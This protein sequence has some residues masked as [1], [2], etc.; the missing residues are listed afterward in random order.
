MGKKGKGEAAKEVAKPEVKEEPVV[1][2]VATN[3]LVDLLGP[4]I[5]KNNGESEAM[6]KYKESESTEKALRGRSVIG[7]FFA[8]LQ[9]PASKAFS[10]ILAKAYRESLYAKGLE[11]VFIS[12]DEK[13][14]DGMTQYAQQ[15]EAMSCVKVSAES[16]SETSDFWY[17]LPKDTTFQARTEL[18]DKFHGEG[19]D[20]NTAL[21]SEGEPRSWFTTPADGKYYSSGNAD[22]HLQAFG[23]SAKFILLSLFSPPGG[24]ASIVISEEQLKRGAGN[25]IAVEG[26]KGFQI[27]IQVGGQKDAWTAKVDAIGPE[28]APMTGTTSGKGH[29]G[30]DGLIR[31]WVGV[32]SPGKVINVR[33][34]DGHQS[35]AGD[36]LGVPNYENAIIDAHAAHEDQP[37]WTPSDF[38]LRAEEPKD[39]DAAVIWTFETRGKEPTVLDLRSPD[40]DL[41]GIYVHCPYA[42]NRD[43]YRKK[44]DVDSFN[45]NGTYL[46]YH[47]TNRAWLADAKGSGLEMVLAMSDPAADHQSMIPILTSEYKYKSGSADAYSIEFQQED[48]GEGEEC[49][50]LVLVDAKGNV[51]THDGVF[52]V[53]TD[54]TGTEFPWAAPKDLTEEDILLRSGLVTPPV[55]EAGIKPILIR[56][57]QYMGY[58][59]TDQEEEDDSVPFSGGNLKPYAVLSKAQIL[60]DVRKMGFANDFHAISKDVEK[61]Q[62]DNLLLLYDPE[63][64]HGERLCWCSTLAAYEKW[65]GIIS[66][67][68]GKHDVQ[69]IAS[70]LRRIKAVDPGQEDL[71]KMEKVLLGKK[72]ETIFQSVAAKLRTA[73]TLGGFD[74]KNSECVTSVVPSSNL[75][76]KARSYAN[77]VEQLWKAKAGSVV[78][79]LFANC[80]Q[81]ADNKPLDRPLLTRL[82][83][84]F[85][86][87][88]GDLFTDERIKSSPLG[89]VA[90][91]LYTMQDVDLDRM[92]LF[93]DVPEIPEGE[94][95][96]EARDRN[97]LPYRQKH[98]GEGRN[99]CMFGEACWALRSCWEAFAGGWENAEA[100]QKLRKWVKWATLVGSLRQKLSLGK[101]VTRGLTQLPDAVMEDLMKRKPDDLIFWGTLSSTTLDPSIS[102]NYANQ[103]RPVN[104]NIVITI[105][106]LDEGIPL[107]QISQYPMEQEVLL[108]CFSMLRVREV[109]P[110]TSPDQPVRMSCEYAGCLIPDSLQGLAEKD[111]IRSMATLWEAVKEAEDGD[112]DVVVRDLP[113]DCKDWVSD[114]AEETHQEVGRFTVNNSRSLLRVMIT[115][116]RAHF[117]KTHKFSDSGEN[118][119]YC[120]PQKDPNYTQQRKELEMGIQAVKE[121]SEQSCQTAW[122]RPVNK[123]TQYSPKDFLPNGDAELGYDKV[124]ELTEFLEKVSVRVEESLQTNETVDIFQ[125]EFAHLGEEEAGAVSKTHSNIK[126]LRT[127]YDVNYTKGKRI[128]CVEWVPN[129][130]DMLACSC[131]ENLTFNERLENAGK[132]TVSTI[133]LWSQQETLSPHCV[134]LAPWDVSVFKFYPSNGKYLVGGLANGQIT[135]WKLSDADL[136]YASRDSKKAGA[137]AGAGIDKAGVEE[138]TGSMPTVPYKQLSIIDES[139]RKAVLAIEWL[140]ATLEFERRGRS[141]SEKNPKDGPVKYFVTIAGDGQLMIW[142]FQALYDSINDNDFMWRPLHKVQLNRQD[143]GTEMGCCHLL[144]CND[145]YDDKGQ[146]LLT[147]W[148]ASTEEGELIFGDWAAR[149]EEDRKPE[150]CKKI[151]TV[152]KTFRPMLSLERSPFFADI[153]LGVT[154]WAFYIW[155]DGIQE[156]LFQ[157]T[158][159]STYFARGLWSPTRPSVIFLGLVSGGIDI[160]DF[161][162]QS[163]KASLT[164]TGA[165][166][167]ISSMTFLKQD[168]HN[169]SEQLLAVGDAQ[170]Y[171][172]VLTIPKNLVR[173]AGRELE[174]MKKF[175][176]RE[177]ARVS[178]FRER[179]DELQTLKEKMEKQ[180]QMAADAEVVD[181]SKAAIDEAKEEAIMEAEYLKIEEECVE[182]LRLGTF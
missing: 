111:N 89:I 22:R 59:L 56:S 156:H 94:E 125:E 101:P 127:F 136:G 30:E 57:N 16:E 73:K 78:D 69:Q 72:R 158:Y 52:E 17:T 93:P 71:E 92:F 106:D 4:S 45:F 169:S 80:Y 3:R 130:S 150:C 60:A 61:L 79:E 32:T 182:A 12:C 38:A 119:Q 108:P 164:D 154:D 133:L 173:P 98:E 66:E 126:D 84:E 166:V 107:H 31:L 19:Q 5:S 14:E 151:F 53:S 77:F 153:L 58:G 28:A 65:W 55:G 29:I 67:L 129:S 41:T 134:L 149:H 115:R 37:P 100:E 159:T 11:V 51:L 121:T 122:F 27:N 97:Y 112:D 91:I 85:K 87:K 46:M 114:T 174:N 104:K 21:Y 177:E 167:E 181:K 120:R 95:D 86:K 148:Y 109:K 113:W 62:G 168:S 165:S 81:E 74:L 118:I 39:S 10:D 146:K 47:E 23:S 83:V 6:S 131:C 163:H 48:D 102:E 43:V 180:A 8:Q 117:G 155:K 82:C 103:K 132:A 40:D 70:H 18:F 15:V 25:E 64:T 99:A 88:Y 26:I 152:S 137:A 50:K 161:S 24:S 176:E 90:L 144:Y 105:H 157:S 68:R 35:I 170:G 178:Y 110:S 7:F 42:F 128:E 116:P 63:K 123:S 142:D 36:N 135:V 179:Q 75:K 1:K 175:L 76:G 138:K 141:A 162:D 33:V 143:S 2:E 124:A 145:R 140:P 147:N 139:H 13:Q 20:R 96:P 54:P 9:H 44:D 34:G 49:P 171:L 172:H 160:W